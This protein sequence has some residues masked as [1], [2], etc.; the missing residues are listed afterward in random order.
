MHGLHIIIWRLRLTN[1]GIFGEFHLAHRRQ[2]EVAYSTTYG[3]WL[4][5]FINIRVLE[6]LVGWSFLKHMERTGHLG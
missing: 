5:H 3:V 1:E 4:C 2:K 6:Q